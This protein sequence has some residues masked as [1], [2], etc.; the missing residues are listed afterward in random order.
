VE[1]LT[2]IEELN[3]NLVKL[4][5]VLRRF[6]GT[7]AEL[8]I[9]NNLLKDVYKNDQDPKLVKI[10]TCNKR[11][12]S[13]IKNVV[14]QL[15]DSLSET[16][17]RLIKHEDRMKLKV[18]ELQMPSP[19]LRRVPGASGTGIRFPTGINIFA[20]SSGSTSSASTPKAVRDSFKKNPN[21]RPEF[22]HEELQKSME[23]TKGEEVNPTEME[24]DLVTTDGEKEK[25]NS[26]VITKE[27]FVER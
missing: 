20:T 3:Q 24:M 27:V 1:E 19:D 10:I 7:E 2:K 5:Y 8:M 17:D 21:I 16:T 4:T 12:A 25:D 6:L 9:A 15:S 23:E 11:Y 18:G 13:E 14:G 26:P 22:L